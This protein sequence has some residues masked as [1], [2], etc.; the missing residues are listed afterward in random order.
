VRSA[1]RRPAGLLIAA[2]AVLL[3]GIA[4]VGVGL[5]L[6]ARAGHPAVISASPSAASTGQPAGTRTIS[7]LGAGDVLL[8]QPVT[9]Q[10]A[11]DARAEGKSGLDYAPIF[12]D[13]KDDIEGADLAICH[14]ETP[15]APDGG[16]YRVYPQFSVPPQITT[17][18]KAVGYDTC[19]TASNHTL[20]QGEPGVDRTLDAL[21][22]VGIKHAGSYR[23]KSA[24]ATPNLL[25]VQP[26]QGGDP[27]TVAQLSY[28]F[29]FNG[30]AKPAGKPWIANQI[31]APAILA[32]AR[33]ARQAGAKIVVVSLHW[34][35]E[36]DNN[37]NA[38]QQSLAR[39]LLASPDIDLILGC[40]AHV[41]Q[42]ME[43]INGKWVIYSMGNEIAQH[44]EPINAN[45]EG[46]MPRITF[47][48]GADGR[49]HTSAAEVIPTWVQLT[50]NLR[51][52]ELPDALADNGLPADTRKIYQSALTRIKGYVGR[53][54][55]FDDGL[56]IPSAG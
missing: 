40:H 38:D 10:A 30:L 41:V 56:T 26:K 8:H 36:Y 24:Q 28:T 14:L 37:S 21:D 50:P 46:I 42:P 2:V 39:K 19:S 13:V 54:G 12:D 52:I 33:K 53:R 55:A 23:S 17:A 47:R 22:A 48:E 6:T 18:L 16:P 3:L 43:Q 20:D 45:R 34:G 11:R 4:G 44:A 51:I 27:V 25:P 5:H 9:D 7:I 29:G 35:I 49:W 1:R 32:E 31:D 15:L